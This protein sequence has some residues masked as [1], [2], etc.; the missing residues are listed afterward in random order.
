MVW[1]SEYG[2]FTFFVLALALGLAFH[3]GEA[4]C[5]EK[6]GKSTT[7]KMVKSDS[8]VH[9]A[10]DRM[11]VMQKERMILFEGHVT[12]Q[13]DDLSVTAQRMRIYGVAGG[14]EKG[15]EKDKDSQSAMME[16]ID[17]IEAEG[18][19]RISQ[20]DKLATSEKAVWYHQERKIVLMGS[21]SVAQGKDKV[22]GRLITMYIDQGKSVVEGG[23]E[24]P[25]QAVLHPSRK[26]AAQ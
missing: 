5:A 20:R 8:P 4:G 10:S 13:Q 3:G 22:Q 9:I 23:E 12:I 7:E 21:P 26:E 19:V 15:K 17:R 24:T 18:N 25:V 1:R 11:E 14:K 2:R 6:P 16:K